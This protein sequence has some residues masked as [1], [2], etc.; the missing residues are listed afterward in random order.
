MAERA[1]VIVDRLDMIKPPVNQ[2]M[3]TLDRSRFTTRVPLVAAVIT[4]N[5]QISDIRRQLTE[6]TAKFGRLQSV[7]PVKDG[8]GILRKALLLRPEIRKNGIFF[9]LHCDVDGLGLIS[10]IPPHGVHD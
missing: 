8:S 2:A 7:R 5:K 3:R 1:E 4:D 9:H 10:Q 6:E